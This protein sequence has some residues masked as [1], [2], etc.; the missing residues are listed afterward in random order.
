VILTP[1]DKTTTI[2]PLPRFTWLAVPEAKTYEIQVALIGGKFDFITQSGLTTNRF[3]PANPL[4][5]ATYR[6]WVRAVLADGTKLPW[7]APST[8]NVV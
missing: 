1:A 2:N 8:F 5:P 3:T 4:N 6:Y 7:S